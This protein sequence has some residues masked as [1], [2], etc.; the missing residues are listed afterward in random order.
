MKS[1]KVRCDNDCPWIDELRYLEGHLQKCE[2]ALI[3]C[4]NQ[5]Q[6]GS[7]NMVK[8]LRK[9]LQNH[10]LNKCPRR[11]I[12]CPQCRETGEYQERISTHLQTC[13]KA[14]VRCP[15]SSSCL[16]IIA[17][18]DIAT[19]RSTCQYENVPCKY[20]EVGCKEKPLRKDL[21][22]HEEDD[23][24]HHRI[25]TE[26]VLDQN[27]KITILEAKLSSLVIETIMD[28]NKKITT[29]EAKLSSLE[30]ETVMDQERKIT[31]L[32]A[33]L[34][35][36]TTSQCTF[37]LTNYKKYKKDGDEFYSPPFYTSTT[38]YKMFIEVEA[39]GDGVGQ[40]THV[41]VFAGLMKGDNDD[42]LTWPFTGSVTFE[43]LNQLEDKNH[44]TFT[45]G[46]FPADGVSSKRVVEGER[47]TNGWGK[48]QFIPH[49]KLDHNPG[50]N[51]QYL[52][53]D[54]VVFRV[55]VDVPKSWLM[56][57]V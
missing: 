46:P 27:K 3:P 4:P 9:N 55:S 23:Q 30:T 57:T 48:R 51:C 33:V 26:T 36:T 53:D 7:N 8:I 16:T 29:L 12:P 10:L 28:Q 54:T 42:S 13:P 18:C 44:H 38:G 19:H 34:K 5:C 6:T 47:A 40:G 37:R 2:R 52:K 35:R 41:S 50:K 56:C 24:L 14:Q 43:L 31:T 11:Q 21:T 20:A 22:A 45:T 32:E 39:N 25:T 1:L 17:R 49:T 15:N